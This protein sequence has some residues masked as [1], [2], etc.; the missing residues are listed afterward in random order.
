MHRTFKSTQ[1]FAFS[2]LIIKYKNHLGQKNEWLARTRKSHAIS[3]TMA[4]TTSQ[5]RETEQC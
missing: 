3:E 5:S 2:F 4:N 1:V